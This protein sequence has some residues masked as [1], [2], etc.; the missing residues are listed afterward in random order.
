MQW[1]KDERRRIKLI[2]MLLELIKIKILGM[3]PNIGGSPIKFIIDTVR[4]MFM[5][6]GKELIV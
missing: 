4:I 1:I 5:Y 3:K 6:K 2:N